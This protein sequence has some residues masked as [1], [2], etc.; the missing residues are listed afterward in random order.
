MAKKFKIGVM[1]FTRGN[2]VL[3]TSKVLKDEFEI[4]SV[5]E[6][7]PEVVEKAKADENMP[8]DG[9]TF[10]EDY[11]EF[12]K[13]GIDAVVL[14]N[15]F[16]DHAKYAI[17]AMDA[18][19]PVFSETTAAPS[20]GECVDLVEAYERTGTKYM[21][22]SNC[23]FLKVIQEMKKLVESKK[24]GSPVYGDAEYAHSP[25][26]R[27]TYKERD[28]KNL[29]WRDTLPR[30]YYNMHDLGPMMFVTNGVPKKVVGKAVSMPN[31]PL[32]GNI[33]TSSKTFG[34]V[35]MDNG[36]VINYAGCTSCG[37]SG[38]WFRLACEYGSL[39]AERFNGYDNIVTC[40]LNGWNKDDPD[41]YKKTRELSWSECGALTEDEEKRLFDGVNLE[42][43]HDGIDVVLM[44]HFIKFL[45][46]EYE[47]FFD[48]YN[49][50]ALSAAGIL[51]WYSALSGSQELEVPNFRDKASRDKVRNDY[52]MPFAK[53]I[54]DLTLPFRIEDKDNFKL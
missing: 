1:G 28:P 41:N 30:C 34:L 29:H 18:G 39:E 13:S 45:A 21:L 22:A 20:L 10:Y 2:F 47:P 25:A 46:D 8:T 43:L 14:C 50:V 24:F 44:H 37:S 32:Y 51:A 33:N 5:C 31:G 35:E 17:K 3:E 23:I 54:D 9:I 12:L 49:S 26:L 40:G 38:K 53:D 6:N 7:N 48:V 11:D 16:P 27:D 4:V 52:R 36:V 15:Y 42:V 19:I